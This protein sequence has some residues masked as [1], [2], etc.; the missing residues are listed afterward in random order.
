MMRRSTRGAGHLVL[1]AAVAAVYLSI[2]VVAAQVGPGGVSGAQAGT[3]EPPVNETPRER[4]LL[5][6]A[7]AGSLLAAG[8]WYLSRRRAGS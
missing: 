3:G 2:L 8:G 6:L 1:R 4:P 5:T 7:V